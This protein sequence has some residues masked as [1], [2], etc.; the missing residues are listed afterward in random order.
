MT[1]FH[2]ALLPYT[3]CKAN[4]GGYGFPGLRRWPTSGGYRCTR[5]MLARAGNK[6]VGFKGYKKGQDKKRGK[7]EGTG[8]MAT[9]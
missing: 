9:S 7:Y 1:T 4:N 5:Y 3:A 2:P 6:G 8:L